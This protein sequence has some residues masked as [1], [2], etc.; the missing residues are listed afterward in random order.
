MREGV[1]DKELQME[2]RGAENQSVDLL[3]FSGP[4]SE[5]QEAQGAEGVEFQR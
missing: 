4:G 2:E 5:P 1:G 3:W